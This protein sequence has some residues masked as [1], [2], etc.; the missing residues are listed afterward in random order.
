MG[1]HLIDGYPNDFN[2]G[3]KMNRYPQSI[4]APFYIYE[5]KSIMNKFDVKLLHNIATDGFTYHVK[6]KIDLISKEEFDVWMRYHLSTCEREDLQVYSNRKID[7]V[8]TFCVI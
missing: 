2:K 6:D 1:N 5:F 8:A 3:F 7:L 4:F